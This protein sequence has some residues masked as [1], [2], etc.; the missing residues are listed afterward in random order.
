MNNNKMDT[1]AFRETQRMR[2]WWV[3]MIVAGMVTVAILMIPQLIFPAP[4]QVFTPAYPTVLF[5]IITLI[6]LLLILL[7]F[8]ARLETRI[9]DS[10]VHYLYFPFYL[11]FRSLRWEEIDEIIVRDYNP[12]REFGGWGIRGTRSNRALT[13]SGKH[14]L[15]LIL[16]NGRRLF[17]GTQKPDEL[18]AV[19]QRLP[20]DAE[21]KSI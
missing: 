9:N 20:A 2:R 10:G 11:K 8:T 16:K 13:V 1:A 17:I 21:N 4:Q 18:L 5:S 7:I 6:I 12:I 19:I 15:Q 3:W 14:G